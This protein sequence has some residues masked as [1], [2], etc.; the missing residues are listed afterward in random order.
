[1]E[2]KKQARDVAREIDINRG[3]CMREVGNDLEMNEKRYIVL[4]YNLYIENVIF[5]I[6]NKSC[7]YFIL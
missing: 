4:L 7:V 6:S 1:M 3:R 2:M 5:I